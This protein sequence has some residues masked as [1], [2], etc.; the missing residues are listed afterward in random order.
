VPL[1]NSRAGGNAGVEDRG[2][3]HK[4][5]ERMV[6]GGGGGREVKCST[7]I[8]WGWGMYTISPLSHR[9]SKFDRQRN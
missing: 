1:W 3:V 7:P 9:R 5:R 8:V 4:I 2:W 6:L